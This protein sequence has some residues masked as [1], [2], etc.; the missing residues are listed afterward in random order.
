MKKWQESASPPITLYSNPVLK[1]GSNNLISICKQEDRL[2]FVFT[3]R[4]IL[5]RV[6][7]GSLVF[8]FNEFSVNKEDPVS[9]SESKSKYRNFYKIGFLH[10]TLYF[11]DRV[12]FLLLALN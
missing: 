1:N 12:R 8:P 6:E 5:A 3:D 4:A 11:Y 9:K 2:G 10:N 7:S